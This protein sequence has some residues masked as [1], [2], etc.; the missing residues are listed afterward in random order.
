MSHT[1]VAFNVRGAILTIFFLYP[2][3]IYVPGNDN[4]SFE[5]P[6]TVWQMLVENRSIQIFMMIYCLTVFGYNLF[7]V[8]VTFSLSSVWHSILDNFRPATVWFIDLCIY[9]S[10]TGSDFGEP[11]TKYSW[12][13]LCGVA[14]LMYGT[15]IYNAPDGGSVCLCGEWYSLGMDFSDEYREIHG[16]RLFS[17]GSY[18]SL[19]RFLTSSW[20]PN[21]AYGRPNLSDRVTSPRITEYATFSEALRYSESL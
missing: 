11:W 12:L 19:Q 13:Q 3:A 16:Q 8:L 21:H 7:A 18:P 14:V 17:M 20:R 2:I 10:L 4:G 9:Y 6:S 5:S 15:A 1:F